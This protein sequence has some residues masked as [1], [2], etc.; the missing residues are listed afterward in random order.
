MLKYDRRKVKNING[1]YS[2]EADTSVLVTCFMLA[3]DEAKL[4]GPADGLITYKPR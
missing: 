3:G 1:R 4:T 2:T